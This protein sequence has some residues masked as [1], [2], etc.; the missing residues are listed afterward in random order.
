[1]LQREAS[2]GVAILAPLRDQGSI[3]GVRSGLRWVLACLLTC[4]A[5]AHA[6][7]ADLLVTKSGPD[8]AAAGDDVSY[9]IEVTNLGPD[10]ANNASLFDPLPP[11]M[12]FVSIAQSGPT[13][14]CTTPGVGFGGNVDCS[15]AL[16]PVGQ[17]TQ[18]TLVAQI[19]PG[20][21]P[22]SSFTNIATVSSQTFDPNSEN[23]SAV[24]GT[25]IPIPSADVYVQKDGP[26]AVGPDA[27]VSYQITLGNA[28]P[29]D[30]ASVSLS[31]TLPGTMTFV[32]LIQDSGPAL[33]C[34]TPGAG[35][36]G[37]INCS[38][39]SLPVGTSAVLTLTGHVPAGTPSGTEF[40]NVVLATAATFDPNSKND[41]AVT[42]ATVSETDLSV[43]KTAP[44]TADAGSDF[45]YTLTVA[46]AGPDSAISV[47]LLDELPAETQLVSITQ[48]TG[49]TFTCGVQAQGP[50]GTI[51]CQLALMGNG[52]SASFTVVV[53]ARPDVP[54]GTVVTNTATLSSASFDANGAND[55]DS[56]S[57]AFN[58]TADLAVTKTGPG[59]LQ[60][61]LTAVYTL[62]LEN[63]GADPAATTVLSD[64]LP[65]E[66]GF[67]SLTQTGAAL[68]CTTPAI[69]ASGAITC[70]SASYASGA[71]TTLALTVQVADSATHGSTVVNSASATTT[72]PE[73]DALNNS[74]S[75]SGTVS[76][77][78]D[79]AIT[80]SAPLTAVAGQT[81]A[82]SIGVSNLGPLADDV[83]WSDTLPP[84]TRFQ[85]L[86]Q[87]AG[88]TFSCTTPAVGAAGTVTCTR[89][90]FANGATAAFTLSVTVDVAAANG[91]TIDNTATVTGLRQDPNGG[92]DSDGA[93]STVSNLAD[94]A[95][96]KTGAATANA[97]QTLIYTLGARND[98]ASPA[99]A[100][101]IA[102]TLPAGTTFVS[103]SQDSGPA[104]T[105]T[106]P[107][108]GA[109]GA[110]GCTLASFASL[111]NAGFTLTVQVDAA[112][113]GGSTIANIATIATSSSESSS[114]NNSATSTAT[115]ALPD[116]A[117]TKTAPAS[118]AP[119]QTITYALT[120]ANSGGS[121]AATVAL[122]DALPASTRF[123]SLAQDSGPAFTCTTPAVNTNGTVSCS[124]ASFAGGATAAFTLVV[125]PA[126]N[127]SGTIANTATATSASGEASTANNSGS[128]STTLLGASPV[129]QVLVPATSSIALLLLALVVMLIA[130]HVEAR[131][132]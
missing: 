115:V 106:T 102:D 56:A 105:C 67:A 130:L 18:F 124:I 46:N 25:T 36:G 89:A 47:Q 1:M 92:N 60:A 107:A 81:L 23:D 10:D 68:A 55:T 83:S 76:S 121:A 93:S 74:A 125:R 99:L 132:D 59:T 73:S 24:A 12:T 49:P 22:G 131:R 108:V 57:T 54:S 96:T 17:S 34:T 44:P 104:F 85:S 6:Q 45:S 103:L 119:G 13:F 40:T 35:S 117:L 37:T 31:D 64:V 51:V 15:I 98:G 58:N 79:R 91:S 11:G 27:D 112:A 29:D 90:A 114:A 61:G 123:V 118:V 126:S 116:L 95:I 41:S 86:T 39:A 53:T 21:P 71:S 127:A 88:A 38:I 19:A 28:G 78:S 77:Q 75:A 70:S 63:L 43:G 42:T 97:G 8:S 50:S 82:Y 62:T 7:E 113:V 14:T 120:L 33:S 100:V 4:A 3:M 101:A 111:A 109:G 5:V 2:H 72:T 30:A 52:A 80:K 65:A 69:G 48:D 26:G 122:T 9:S 128:A 16:L 129:N 32:S 84:N 110:I 94:V 20:T 87:D 66:L